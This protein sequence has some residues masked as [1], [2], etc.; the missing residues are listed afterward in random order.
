MEEIF[1]KLK[2]RMLGGMVFHDEMATYYDFLGMCDMRDEHRMHYAEETKGYHKLCEYYMHHY[3]KLIPSLPMERPNV[4]PESWYQYKRTDV[5]AGTRKN[6]VRNGARSWIEW[7]SQTKDLYEEMCGEL[8]NDGEIA[9]AFFIAEYVA[10]VDEE[11]AEAT[12]M[13]IQEVT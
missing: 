13:H 3:N 9:S 2:A 11:L 5:D 12:S 1:A 8:L 10:D 4:I 7:E 6:A